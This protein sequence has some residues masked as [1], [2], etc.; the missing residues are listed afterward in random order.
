MLNYVAFEG[1]D[2]AGKG[3][4]I[5][6]LQPWLARRYYTPINLFEPTYGQYG[7][8]IRKEIVELTHS[9]TSRQTDLLTEDRRQHVRYKIQPL[10]DFVR[11][12]PFFL[13]VQD[14]CYFSA[15][16]YQG[17]GKACMLSMLKAQ[18]KIAP[19]PD[20]VFLID[21]PVDDAIE[22]QVQSGLPATLFERKETLERVR[23]NY[24]LIAAEFRSTIKLIDGRGAPECVNR[25]ITK[26]LAKELR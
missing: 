18:Q 21:L 26:I 20:I 8:A 2:Y 7:K 17:S 13:I 11:R 5:A 12:H 14:R 23:Q 22:R 24:L 19:P 16:A 4:Q 25:R 6:L 10:L 15:P 1:I 9:S 3:T